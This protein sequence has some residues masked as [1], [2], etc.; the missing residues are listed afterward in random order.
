M[1]LKTNIK[2][3]IVELMVSAAL[4]RHNKTVCKPITNQCRYD[5]IFE[6]SGMFYRVQCKHGVTK[7]GAIK[8]C[9]SNTTGM[10]NI[11][12]H[13]KIF[14]KHYKKDVDYFGV[15]SLQNNKTYLIPIEFIG[16]SQ[17]TLRITEPGNNQ[18]KKI[19][20]AKHYEI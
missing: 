10:L 4:L 14:K 12:K 1:E 2:G 17:T 3:D 11:R 16:T 8:F 20:W 7:N 13:A 5:L 6:D 19:L 18:Y 15:Y 9:T